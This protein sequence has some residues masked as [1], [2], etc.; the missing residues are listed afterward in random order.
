MWNVKTTAFFREYFSHYI[1]KYQG[2]STPSS[3]SMSLF[4]PGVFTLRPKR[5][6][7]TASCPH[8]IDTERQQKHFSLFSHSH[9]EGNRHCRRVMGERWFEKKKIKQSQ[10]SVVLGFFKKKKKKKFLNSQTMSLLS[11]E[12]SSQ[13]AETPLSRQLHFLTFHLMWLFEVDLKK[14]GRNFHS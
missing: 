5:A 11:W 3:P 14:W 4:F 12:Q 1:R 13:H 10:G 6:S 8:P 2:R 7:D 9:S